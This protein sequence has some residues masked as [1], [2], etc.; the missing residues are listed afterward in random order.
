MYYTAYF[1]KIRLYV[2]NN[3]NKQMYMFS[4]NEKKRYNKDIIL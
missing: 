1:G 4:I 3:V 2:K